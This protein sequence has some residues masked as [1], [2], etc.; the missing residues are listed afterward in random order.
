M[1]RRGKRSKGIK[2]Y[3]SVDFEGAACVIGVPDKPMEMLGSGLNTGT[4]VFRQAQ[5]LV[6]AEVN[7][8]VRGAFVGG[9]TE[10][11]VEDNHG[12]GHNLLYEELHPDASVLM[13][14][15][16]PRRFCLLDRSFAGIVLLCYHARAGTRGGVLAHSFSSVAIHEMRL[17]GKPIGEIGMDAACAGARGVPVILVSG[18]EAACAEA[19]KLLGRDVET[20]ATKRGISRNCALSLS[21]LRAQELIQDG[22]KRAVAKAAHIRPLVLDGPF[23]MDRVFKWETQA[24]AAARSPNTERLDAY[25]VRWRAKTI[26]EL[27]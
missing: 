21:P 23:V 16:R 3:L 11:L 4:E 5:R 20:V 9:A 27:L 25:T 22:M 26:D 7:A 2:I 13:G 17:N 10:V 14:A 19:R 12:P 15:P 6:T 1:A 18:D 24:D 8:A